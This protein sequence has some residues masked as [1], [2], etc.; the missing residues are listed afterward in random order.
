MARI[1]AAAAGNA[2]NIDVRQLA[3]S[4]LQRL[5]V[6]EYRVLFAID[7]EAQFLGSN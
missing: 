2:P 6:G 1:E 5:R 3:G 7:P 4:D